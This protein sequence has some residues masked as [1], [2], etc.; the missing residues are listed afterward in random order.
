MPHLGGLKVVSQSSGIVS[1]NSVAKFKELAEIEVRLMHFLSMEQHFPELIGCLLIL[2]HGL[3][4]SGLLEVKEAK[5]IHCLNIAL[6]C[7]L[8]VKLECL[9]HINFYSMSELIADA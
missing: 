6:S 5:V 3:C 1:V 7:T 2:L 9:V 8:L 4:L